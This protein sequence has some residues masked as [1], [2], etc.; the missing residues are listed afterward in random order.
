[1]TYFFANSLSLLKP[2]TTGTN[3]STINLATSDC[4]LSAST[5][6]VNFYVSTLVEFFK[7]A[8]AA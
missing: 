8:F 7:S 5:L 4:K 6:L 3:L 1:M 2:L